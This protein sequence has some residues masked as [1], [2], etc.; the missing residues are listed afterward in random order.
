MKSSG[1]DDFKGEFYQTVKEEIILILLK[2]FRKL[3]E[4]T[5]PNS[6]CE[7]SITLIPKAKTPQKRKS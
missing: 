3:E 5:L 4:G 2:L 1:Q 6:F 7:T